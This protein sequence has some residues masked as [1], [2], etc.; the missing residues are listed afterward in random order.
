MFWV[1]GMTFEMNKDTSGLFVVASRRAH[2][3]AFGQQ[4]RKHTVE[5]HTKAFRSNGVPECNDPRLPRSVKG[6]QFGSPANILKAPTQLGRHRTD[7]FNGRRC[8][9]KGGVHAVIPC[10]RT[11]PALDHLGISV[12]GLLARR[13]AHA[14]KSG[15]IWPKCRSALVGDRDYGQRQG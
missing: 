7:R 10:A 1:G 14:T 11:V 5:A 2:N 3:T 4:F 15:F 9:S 8:F 13:R 6:N 12:N